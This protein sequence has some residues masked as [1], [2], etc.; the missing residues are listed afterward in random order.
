MRPSCVDFILTAVNYR[1]RSEFIRAYPIVVRRRKI[2]KVH[3][4]YL[5][6]SN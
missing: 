6:I 3:R 1:T 4:I 2:R 5:T